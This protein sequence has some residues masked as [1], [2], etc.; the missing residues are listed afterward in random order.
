M[1][2]SLQ[3]D[4]RPVVL[5]LGEVLWY[6]APGGKLLSGSPATFAYHAQALG[7]EAF[8]VS[9]VGD[10]VLG[11]E[12]LERLDRLQ[13]SRQYVTLDPMHPTGTVSV[14]LNGQT[15]PEYI[16]PRPAAWDFI[17]PDGNLLWLAERIDAVC[18]GSLAQ[19]STVSRSTI[20]RLL[21]A[22]REDC[23]RIF[24]LNLRQGYY[25]LE[26]IV[27]G[28]ALANVLKLNERELPVVAKMLSISERNGD[29]LTTLL[30]R[31][32]LKLVALTRGQ[33]GSVLVG[34]EGHSVH[35]AMPIDVADTAGAGD[36]FAAVIAMGMLQGLELGVINEHANRVAGY[37][38]SQHDA[39]PP[40][41]P[42]LL[43]FALT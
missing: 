24:D 8:V 28:L 14:Q 41:P 16:I 7:A 13:L 23:L 36:A 6:M 20:R 15:E 43:R 2:E 12:I 29:V 18:F 34:P 35:P 31:Y 19:R 4:V 27:N 30:Q 37:V 32:S 17:R 22:T 11:M 26:T 25:Y 39:M 38:C 42:E 10:D 3:Y 5:G 9:R 40:M 21:A 33:R 1:D